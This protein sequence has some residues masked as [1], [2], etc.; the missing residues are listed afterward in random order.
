LFSFLAERA[1]M[2]QHCA[3]GKVLAFAID[4]SNTLFMTSK[5]EK[6]IA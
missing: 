4:T 6:G 2:V 5:Y 1:G 3:V